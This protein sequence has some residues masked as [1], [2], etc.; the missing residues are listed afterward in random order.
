MNE[1]RGERMDDFY[2]IEQSANIMPIRLSEAYPPEWL[3]QFLPGDLYEN[4]KVAKPK[5]PA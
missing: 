3:A 1:F 5:R 2:L 4:L